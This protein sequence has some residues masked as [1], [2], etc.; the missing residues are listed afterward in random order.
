MKTTLNL[1]QRRFFNW[2][3]AVLLVAGCAT[4]GDPPE[5]EIVPV[6]PPEGTF[7]VLFVGNSLTYTNDLPRIVERMLSSADI[8]PVAVASRLFPNFGLQDHWV[9]LNTLSAVA[10]GWDV[11]IMQQGPSATEGRPSLLQY[12]ELFANEIRT[13][14]GEPG[15]YMVWPSVVRD[16][17]FDGVSESYAMAADRVDGLLFPAG[18]AWRSAWERDETL[19]LYGPD[20]F[21]PSPMGTYLAALV[22][23]EQLS[24]QSLSSL[25]LDT[26]ASLGLFTVDTEIVALLHE[27]A[28]E[29]NA[30]FARG[31]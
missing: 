2:L 22:I 28:A 17:D 14:G 9:N 3:I 15:L 4:T 23:Y 29:A 12:S 13:A 31:N 24:G 7:G 18:E 11:V 8:G 27:A 25:S 10:G 5:Q 20:G 1:W 21:H 6:G 19:P 16:F 30:Q 26:P